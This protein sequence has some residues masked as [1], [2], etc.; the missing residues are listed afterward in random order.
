MGEH[1]SSVTSAYKCIILRITIK[2]F[3]KKIKKCWKALFFI[4]IIVEYIECI[5]LKEV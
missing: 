2:Q 5:S 4:L 3:N 1:S